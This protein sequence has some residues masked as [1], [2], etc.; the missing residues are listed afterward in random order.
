MMPA[1]TESAVLF[2]ALLEPEEQGRAALYG[3]LARL[4][5]AAPDQDLLYAIAQA[6]DRA[7]YAPQA[8]LGQA[9]RALQMACQVADED[10]LADEFEQLFIGL[11]QGEVVPYMSWH[12]TGFLMEEPLARLRNDLSDLGL[13][14]LEEVSEPEDHMAGILEV[15]RFLIEGDANTPAAALEQQQRFFEAHLRSWYALYA[16][17]VEAAPSANYYRLV[18]RLL[19]AFMDVE[20]QSFRIG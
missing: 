17:Q 12:L 13:A 18:A 3:L 10:A 19:L 5:Y 2:P 16:A 7:A 15:M 11:G 1:Q 14:R 6:D 8:Q 4:L 20:A 9:W